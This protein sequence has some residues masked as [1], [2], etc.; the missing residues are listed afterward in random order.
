MTHSKGVGGSA[1]HDLRREGTVTPPEHNLKR[2]GGS[3]SPRQAKLEDPNLPHQAKSAR[4]ERRATER[5]ERTGG[6]GGADEI[7]PNQAGEADRAGME[8]A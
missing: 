8:P 7:P 2:S 1:Q 5:A 3:T 6:G 4:E